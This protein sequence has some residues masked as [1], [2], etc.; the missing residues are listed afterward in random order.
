MEM[1]ID[2]H[3]PNPRKELLETSKREPTTSGR[4]YSLKERKSHTTY[5]SQYILLTDEGERECYDEAI[6]ND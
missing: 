3:E 1:L 4:R 5:A 2:L 6:A